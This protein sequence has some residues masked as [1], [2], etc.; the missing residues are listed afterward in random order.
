M[1]N[2][3]VEEK[4]ISREILRTAHRK[5]WLKQTIWKLK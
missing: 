3:Q 2:F 4:S 5:I 1:I